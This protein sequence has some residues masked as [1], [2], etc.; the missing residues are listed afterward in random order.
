MRNEQNQF[1]EKVTSLN[2]HYLV[3]VDEKNRMNRPLFYLILFLLIALLGMFAIVV[4]LQSSNEIL[5]SRVEWYVRQ[6]I[7]RDTKDYCYFC[8]CLVNSSFIEL[9]HDS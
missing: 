3:E 7:K 2:N 9:S 8:A 4:I 6:E 5:Q 1:I